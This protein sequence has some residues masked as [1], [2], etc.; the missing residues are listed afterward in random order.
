MV[1]E[2]HTHVNMLNKAVT[3]ARTIGNRV[4]LVHTAVVEMCF[5]I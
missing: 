1:L 3:N 4:S 2:F 5:T